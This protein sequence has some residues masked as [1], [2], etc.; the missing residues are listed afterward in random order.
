[1]NE[2]FFNSIVVAS[3]LGS[4][5]IID[6]VASDDSIEADVGATVILLASAAAC[7]W[8]KVTTRPF[9]ISSDKYCSTTLCFPV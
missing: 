5:F 6:G 1:M 7:F 4:V 8:A 3:K 2:G 9:A